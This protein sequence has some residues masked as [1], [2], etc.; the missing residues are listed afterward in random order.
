MFPV[1][2]LLSVPHP[3]WCR[4]CVEWMLGSVHSSCCLLLLL[5]HT[6]LLP[7]WVLP[8]A[9]VLQDKLISAWVLRRLLCRYL[10]HHVPLRGL[11][12]HLLLLLEPWCLRGCFSRSFPHPSL[13]F[14]SFCHCLN[15]LS[16]KDHHLGCRLSCVTARAWA[17]ASRTVLFCSKI[18]SSYYIWFSQYGPAD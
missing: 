9:A 11:Q 6:S 3:R 13:L 5:S 2:V 15:G 8:W 14:S 17:P 16:P 4:A 1:S 12:R 18:K 7:A 10:F